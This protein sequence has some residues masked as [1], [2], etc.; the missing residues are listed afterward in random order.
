MKKY[1]LV[2]LLAAIVFCVLSISFAYNNYKL[3][4]ANSSLF[5]QLA[6]K[7]SIVRINETTILKIGKQRNIDRLNFVKHAEEIH[8]ELKNKYRQRIA[9]YISIA[10]KYK[11]FKDS[12][13]TKDTSFVNTFT[14]KPYSVRYFNEWITPNE[15]RIRGYFEKQEPYLIYFNDV[16]LNLQADIFLSRSKDNPLWS[17]TLGSNSKYLSTND[18]NVTVDDQF[19]IKKKWSYIIGGGYGSSIHLLGG[20]MYNDYGVSGS[21]IGDN[22]AIGFL[23]KY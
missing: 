10:G 4:D 7:D 5:M 9:A 15:L 1:S 14:S 20:I 11:A 12:V 6:S 23:Y 22:W 8:K 13:E 2:Y 18:I 21:A 3:K 17:V 19:N 16:L